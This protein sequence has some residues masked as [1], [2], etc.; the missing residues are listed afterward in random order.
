[1]PR[2]NRLNRSF[3]LKWTCFLYSKWNLQ[4]ILV[5]KSL[6]HSLHAEILDSIFF[7]AKAMTAVMI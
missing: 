6:R 3:V 5:K 7:A 1:M 4:V 2:K